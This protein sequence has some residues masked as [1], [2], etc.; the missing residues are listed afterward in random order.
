MPEQR[1]E[2]VSTTC[3]IDADH[4]GCHVTR[5]SHMVVIVLFVKRAPIVWYSKHQNTVE[6]STFGSEF[7][8]MRIAIDQTEGLRQYELRMM[9]VLLATRPM[10][11]FCDNGLVVRNSSAPESIL[12]KKHN[13]IAYHCPREACTST[14]ISIAKEDGTMNIADVLTKL[15]GPRLQK[16]VSYLLW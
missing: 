13:A 9:G 4:A 3:F 15:L 2:K 11:L 16:M 14:I 5:S 10:A 12:K 1:G 6:T 8:A 7:I